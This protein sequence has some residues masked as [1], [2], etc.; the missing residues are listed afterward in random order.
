MQKATLVW[1]DAN[2]VTVATNVAT[3]AGMGAALAAMAG[4]S[5]AAI[6]QWWESNVTL[7]GG[8]P[9]TAQFQSGQDRAALT[10]VTGA[11]TQVVMVVPAPSAA[12]FM[13]DLETVDITNPAVVAFVTAA[14]AAPITD[15]AGNAVTALVSGTRQR[16]TNVPL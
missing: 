9:V 1:I 15:G 11:G 6:Q 12:I 8:S 4:L 10:F 16:R 14:V 13:A 2:G 3:T 7:P 5:N